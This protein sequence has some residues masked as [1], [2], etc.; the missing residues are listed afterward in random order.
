V[1][2]Y[3]LISAI[4]SKPWLLDPAWAE[5]NLALVAALLEG[6]AVS[7][8]SKPIS[9]LPNNAPEW[10]QEDLINMPRVIDVSAGTVRAS[11][12]RSFD[13]A[14]KGSIAMIP[15]VGPIS[16]YYNCGVPGSADMTRWV[17]EA[18][19]SSKIEGLIF[20]HDTPGGMVDGTATFAD[21]IRNCSKPTAGFVDDG[22]AASAGMWTIS[23][24]DEILLSQPTDMIGSIG[25]YTQLAD[26]Q[27]YF[28]KLGIKIHQIY[29]PQ[30]SDKNGDY[31]EALKGNYQKVEA[32]LHFLAE[33]FINTIKSNRG[34]KI[35]LS[36][37]DPFTGKMYFAEEAIK[38][39]LAD[40]IGSMED[41]ILSV[42]NRVG[43]KKSTSQSQSNM[44][45]FGNKFP[46][47][48]GLKGKT[49]E[50]VSEEDINAVNAE[51]EGEG[52]TGLSIVPSSFEAD[53]A[54]LIS[55][56]ATVKTLQSDLA[57][58]KSDLSAAQKALKDE[59]DAHSTTNTELQ[60]LK[61]STTADGKKKPKA[62]KDPET[63]DP[64]ADEFKSPA[65]AQLAEM[66]ASLGM[67]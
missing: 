55:E 44:A 29:A 21:A 61:D 46:T 25:V 59:Q 19:D 50:E 10:M 2:N 3:G 26:Y 42:Y 53:A 45:L 65:D 48:S 57:K 39:G 22:M 41:A 28:D 9:S 30:S 11:F 64:E 24:C 34:D 54:K 12:Y 27:G 67:I 16:K 43:T 1:Q 40:R 38:I 18:Q 58:A 32:E 23:S 47:L 33:T 49:S 7:Y 8:P 35:D 4:L 51:L 17:R 56:N 60:E 37:G 20:V 5:A 62:D 15:V 13:E 63:I 66:K 31:K 14:P 36:A 6:K 52:I